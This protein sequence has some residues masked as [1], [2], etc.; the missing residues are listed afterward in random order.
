[1]LLR[2]Q[3]WH[4]ERLA[5]IEERLLATRLAIGDGHGCLQQK[6]MAE[7]VREMVTASRGHLGERRRVCRRP[8]VGHTVKM[9]VAT[10]STMNAVLERRRNSSGKRAVMVA[11]HRW[12][13]EPAGGR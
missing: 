5:P 11:G 6:K 3:G 12:R 2:Q 1:M 8:G 4:G 10:E 9:A 7:M 13:D